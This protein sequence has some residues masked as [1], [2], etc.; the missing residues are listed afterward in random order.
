MLQELDFVKVVKILI[1]DRWVDREARELAR[2]P[3]VG[4]SGVVVFIA[5]G[6]SGETLYTVESMHNGETLWLADFLADELE[7]IV[8]PT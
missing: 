8:R 5:E 4:D 6:S 1:P 7:L 3:R 2:M